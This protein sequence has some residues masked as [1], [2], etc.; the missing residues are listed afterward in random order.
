LIEPILEGGFRA[1]GGPPFVVSA[2]GATRDEA[3]DRLRLEIEQRITAGVVVVPMEVG[4][5]LVNPWLKGAGM[6]RDN[7]LFDAW[8]E[9]IADYRR[10]VDQDS[11]V[12]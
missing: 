3:L 5:D 12:Q 11:E 8:Q 2:Q 10:S 1:T 4:P 7:P 6:F 9:S